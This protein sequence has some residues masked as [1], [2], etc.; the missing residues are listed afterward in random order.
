MTRSALVQ[1]D[2]ILTADEQ[3]LIVQVVADIESVY[4]T[5]SV[6]EWFGP[7]WLVVLEKLDDGQQLFIASRVGIQEAITGE[8]VEELIDGVKK[9]FI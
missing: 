4:D 2:G 9:V 3:Q 7:P 1:F 5:T 8:T 6:P